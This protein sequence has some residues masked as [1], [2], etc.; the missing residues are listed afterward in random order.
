MPR[1]GLPTRLPPGRSAGRSGNFLSAIRHGRSCVHS[2]S[3]DEYKIKLAAAPGPPLLKSSII[4]A[5]SGYH[6]Q[7]DPRRMRG[8]MIDADSGFL[9]IVRPAG[10]NIYKGLRVPV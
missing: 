9:K 1:K 6:R 5:G 2:S 7:G 10:G 3:C 8:V 4:I